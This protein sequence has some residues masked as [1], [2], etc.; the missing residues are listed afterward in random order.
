M[1]KFTLQNVTHVEI[2]E[3]RKDNYCF[4]GDMKNYKYPYIIGFDNGIKVNA[5][6]VPEAIE[7]INKQKML[8]KDKE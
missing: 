3:P 7:W 6:S 5:E 8:N 2:G 4:H 1:K